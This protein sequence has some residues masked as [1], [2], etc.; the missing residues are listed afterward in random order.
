MDSIES[1]KEKQ[2][3]VQKVSPIWFQLESDKS[4]IFLRV[5]ETKKTLLY[6]WGNC[7]PL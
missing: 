3:I 6:F 5:L 2:N 1:D 7:Y 4:F